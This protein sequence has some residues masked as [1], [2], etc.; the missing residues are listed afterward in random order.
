LLKSDQGTWLGINRFGKFAALTNYRE[1]YQPPNLLSRGAI[2][3]LILE[4]N[5]PSLYD[6]ENILNQSDKYG[7]FNLIVSD[8]SLSEP[9]CYY[10]TNRENVSIKKLNKNEIYGLS[11]SVLENPWPKVGVGIS[12]MKLILEESTNE[13][14]LV[15][16][17]FNL[18]R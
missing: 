5:E 1:N 12:E 13:S 9:T 7:G 8:L 17:L 18:L 16:R 14:E 2:V 15:D 11:N 4:S 10:L 3:K 6:L